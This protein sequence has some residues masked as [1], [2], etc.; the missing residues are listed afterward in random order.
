MDPR[1]GLTGSFYKRKHKD[2]LISAKESADAVDSRRRMPGSEG[3]PANRS[4]S[5]IE[6]KMLWSNKILPM[7]VPPLFRIINVE[8]RHRR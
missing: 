2:F 7:C 1:S 6:P 5:A 4:L 8:Y 3:R